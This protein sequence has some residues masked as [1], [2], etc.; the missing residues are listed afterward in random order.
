[1]AQT[2]LITKKHVNGTGNM[3]HLKEAMRFNGF[4]SFRKRIHK[5]IQSNAVLVVL[6]AVKPHSAGY[7]STGAFLQHS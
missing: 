4:T 3:Y 7:L 2:K 1:M 6:S 5:R